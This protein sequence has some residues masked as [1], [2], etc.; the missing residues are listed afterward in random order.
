MGK[1]DADADL[2]LELMTEKGVTKA[3]AHIYRRLTTEDLTRDQTSALIGARRCIE[4]FGDRQH[5]MEQVREHAELIEEMRKTREAMRER[6]GG[7]TSFEGDPL[8]AATGPGSVT[9]EH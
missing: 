1:R 6:G 3:M 4:W 2:A 8:Q 9:T 5:E 7:Q